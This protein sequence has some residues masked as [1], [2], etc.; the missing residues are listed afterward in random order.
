MTHQFH[1]QKIMGMR[2]SRNQ[3][4]AGE[5]DGGDDDDASDAIGGSAIL[6]SSMGGANGRE[7]AGGMAGAPPP[8]KGGLLG[9]QDVADH[10]TGHR[11]LVDQRLD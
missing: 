7:K 2:Q 1:Y 11:G 6:G 5:D 10:A 9:R 8:R 3:D 4:D